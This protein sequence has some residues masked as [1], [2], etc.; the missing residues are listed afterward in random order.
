L[1]L[2]SRNE[3]VYHPLRGALFE[4]WVVSEIAKLITQQGRFDRLFHYRDSKKLEVDLIIES[5]EATHLLEVKSG[6]T[7]ASDS[8]TTLRKLSD[9]VH[10]NGTQPVLRWLV[11]GGEQQQRRLD[12]TALPW[13]QVN[14]VLTTGADVNR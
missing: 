10:S 7:L 12:C 13:H 11:Y 2:G 8:F 6:A 1:V 5:P 4:S 9:A 14:E 3:L